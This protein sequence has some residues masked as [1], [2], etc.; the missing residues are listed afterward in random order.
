[1]SERKRLPVYTGQFFF[2][3]YISF[4]IAT[5]SYRWQMENFTAKMPHHHCGTTQLK[6]DCSH[7][8][9]TYLQASSAAASQSEW[10]NCMFASDV[11]WYLTVC[12]GMSDVYSRLIKWFGAFDILQ[13]HCCMNEPHWGVVASCDC[14]VHE[15]QRWGP[16]LNICIH[17]PMLR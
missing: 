4:L 15:V 16:V 6:L 17:I 3:H 14:W 11:T 1:M 12:W 9:L 13:P 10:D 8:T 2:F 5:S 7:Y